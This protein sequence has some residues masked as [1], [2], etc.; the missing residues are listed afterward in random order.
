MAE[1]FLDLCAKSIGEGARANV[2]LLRA[3]QANYAGASVNVEGTEL[4]NFGSCSYMGLELRTELKEGAIEAVRK[5]GTQF[6]FAKPQVECALYRELETALERMTEGKVL[7]ASSATLAHL[8]ALPALI[9]PKD[10]I[11]MDRLA[12]ASIYTATALIKNVP[13]EI[14]PHSR[15]DILAAR[16]AELS[17]KHERVWYILDGVYSMSGDFAPLAKVEDLL[18]EFPKLHLYSDDAHCTSWLGTHGRGFTLRI[19]DRKRIIVILSLNKAFSAAGAALIVPTDEFRDRIRFAG[20]AMM[21]SGPIQPPMLGAA[22][23]SAKFHLAPEFAALQQALL[24]RIQRLHQLAEAHGVALA[25][26]DLTP[27]AFVPCGKDEAM[28]SLFHALCKRGYYVAPAVFPAVPQS[29]S[30]LR[31]TASLHNTAEETERLMEILGSEMK[32]IPEIVEYQKGF[33]QQERPVS[34][35]SMSDRSL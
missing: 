27:I 26:K 20:A 4:R 35:L 8:A 6:P 29:R 34:V 24:D 25:T 15:M 21:F 1:D 13:L 16:V 32:K 10:A 33:A 12:H 14:L 17:K 7:I 9:S 19:R 28:Y 2:L 30:G 11:V 3:G 5:Y 23:A 18:A 31:L 22:A